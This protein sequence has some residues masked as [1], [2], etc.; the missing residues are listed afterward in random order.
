MGTRTAFRVSPAALAL[1]AFVLWRRKMQD[2][3]PTKPGILRSNVSAEDRAAIIA[4]IAAHGWPEAEVN[5]V[6]RTESGWRTDARNALTNASGLIQLM[7]AWFAR[8]RFRD[9]LKTGTERAA[10]FRKLS[11][12]EQLPWILQYFHEVGRRWRIPGDTY[13]AVAAPA[14]VGDPDEKVIWAVGSKAWQQNPA[15][16][17]SAHGPI[18]AGSIRRV[19]LRKLGGSNV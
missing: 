14:H 7:P 8:H 11:A 19:I 13:M 9:D 6:I 1:L 10:E 17:E 15:W 5:A 18:T 16:R 4:A 3:A 12:R 2:E